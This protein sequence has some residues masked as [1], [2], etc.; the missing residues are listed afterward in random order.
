MTEDRTELDERGP[1]G[2]SPESGRRVRGKPGTEEAKR[3][4]RKQDRSGADSRRASTPPDPDEQT[5]ASG[6]Q[7]KLEEPFREDSSSEGD[8]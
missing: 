2:E 4:A 5:D 6:T 7:K 8:G 3:S 1:G